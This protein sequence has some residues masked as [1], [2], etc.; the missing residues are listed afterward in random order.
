M[1]KEVA[2]LIFS[3][4]NPRSWIVGKMKHVFY[5]IDTVTQKSTEICDLHYENNSINRI[6]Q[7]IMLLVTGW[8]DGV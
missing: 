5:T 8:M 4:T 1:R 7:S 2:F 3:D 6:S